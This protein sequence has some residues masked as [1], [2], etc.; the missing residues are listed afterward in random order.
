ILGVLVRD[1]PVSMVPQMRQERAELS[2]RL[3]FIIDME[4]NLIQLNLFVSGMENFCV[5]QATHLIFMSSIQQ[6]GSKPLNT[7]TNLENFFIPVFH[8]KEGEL[9]LSKNSFIISTQ[10][11]QRPFPVTHYLN[12][13]EDRTG[14]W[15]I[16]PR[17]QSGEMLLSKV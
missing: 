17:W 8:P 11:P 12:I 14:L 3:N 16:I 7:S 2:I 5:S 13:G 1:L 10:A 15:E 6:M 9:L 4:D